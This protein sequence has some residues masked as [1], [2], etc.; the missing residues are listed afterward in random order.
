MIY[1]I[2]TINSKLPSQSLQQTATSLTLSQLNRLCSTVLP[3]FQKLSSLS[4][5]A[6]PLLLKCAR[7][8]V[9]CYILFKAL[10]WSTLIFHPKIVRMTGTMTSLQIK[11]L[12][13][14]QQPSPPSKLNDSELYFNLAKTLPNN[15]SSI[16]INDKT[17][18]RQYLYCIAIALNPDHADSYAHLAQTLS[19]KETKL[20]LNQ[21]VMT[22]ETL[23]TQALKLNPHLGLP[24]LLLGDLA[25]QQGAHAKI[26]IGSALMS[27][28]ELYYLAFEC[29][30]SQES[31]LKLAQTVHEGQT[32]TFLNGDSM[33][34]TDLMNKAATLGSLRPK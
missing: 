33:S 6:H 18:C 27:A 25:L 5:T 28:Q 24:Y 30:P 10:P 15:S 14:L 11:L 2:S 8:V 34:R 16:L 17:F 4:Y 21:T 13:Q 31:C 1:P 20:L 9:S 26:A 7:A 22:L 29:D 19:P 32:I 3:L 12:L 23:C